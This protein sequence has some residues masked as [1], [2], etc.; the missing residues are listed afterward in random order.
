MDVDEPAVAEGELRARLELAG[1]LGEDLPAVVAEVLE[2]EQLDGASRRPAT[3]QASL[4]VVPR[5]RTA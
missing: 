5:L 4:W 3:D 2:Q 1:G